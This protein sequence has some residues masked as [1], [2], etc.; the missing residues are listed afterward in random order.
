M[1]Y[2][3]SSHVNT[4]TTVSI[5]LN[6]TAFSGNLVNAG[7]VSPG[8]VSVV[9][10]TIGGF[11]NDGSVAAGFAVAESTLDGAISNSGTIDG[12]IRANSYDIGGGINNGSGGV[13]QAAT[14][15]IRLASGIFTGGINNAGMISAT[16]HL[17]IGLYP[18]NKFDGGIFNAAGASISAQGTGIFLG[19]HDR[20]AGGI[21]NNGTISSTSRQDIFLFDVS[22]FSGGIVNNG[23]MAGS[24]FA[25]NIA[26]NTFTG[27]IRNTGTMLSQNQGILV[28]G[29]N[30][31][32]GG[33]YTSTFTGG[34]TNTGTL[35]AANT[36]VHV[37][38]LPFFSGNIFN[39]G[40]IVA[41]TPLKLTN[42]PISGSIVNSGN[43]SASAFGIHLEPGSTVRGDVSNAGGIVA[44]RTGILIRHSTITGKIVNSDRIS[45]GSTAITVI[46]STVAGGIS[47]FGRLVATTAIGIYENS[48][49]AGSIADTGFVSGNIDIG[50]GSV[51]KAP[52]TAISITGSTFSG[53]VFN[54]GTISGTTG[55][56][57]T[58]QPSVTVFDGG[59]IVG[60]GGTA[61][62][63][64][65]G[66]TNTFEIVSGYSITGKVLGGSNGIF[67]L[68]GSGSAAEIT[69][70]KTRPPESTS[71][72]LKVPASVAEM[73]VPPGE[74][75]SKPNDLIVVAMALPPEKTTSWAGIKKIPL[76]STPLSVAPMSVPPEWTPS[77]VL[78]D[79]NA[80][81]GAVQENVFYTAT[82]D[83]GTDGGSARK[84][85]VPE[86]D[87]GAHVGAAGG[88]E[89]YTEAVDRGAA[90]GAAS[91]NTQSTT[92]ACIIHS[93]QNDLAACFNQL[94]GATDDDIADVGLAGRNYERRVSLTDH[95]HRDLLTCGSS[96][97]QNLR[98][99]LFA[100]RH[101]R[102]IAFS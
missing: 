82:V 47:N 74:T 69:V 48:T 60:T 11:L 40:T 33:N 46:K 95:R 91:K 7:S 57:V 45:A 31:L 29:S 44:N 71:S 84:L 49:I 18:D 98:I 58:H 16:H 39:G 24:S 100:A 89:F 66:G 28:N 92:E 78:V 51:V 67:E 97:L 79:C 5:N 99:A 20:F 80:D 30:Q 61:V 56:V 19:S 32:G 3:T 35:S 10:S 4:G 21:T 41:R 64:K 94:R 42:G 63:L 1:S 43:L 87:R 2:N 68:G 9:S 25:I 73:P 50:S 93:R 15:A 27:G 22:T 62:N 6:S 85:Q 72:R 36:G 101:D 90:G 38:N 52:G 8:G 37:Q 102:A 75:P 96:L 77:P 17:G 53:V 76:I 65:G 14:T 55:I 23:T 70:W 54:S 81:G 12:G 59:K 13:I 34:V 83:S 26:A 86:I 88:N